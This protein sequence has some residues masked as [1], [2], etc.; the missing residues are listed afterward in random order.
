MLK[1][2]TVINRGQA[3]E[4]D[5]VAPLV[6]GCQVIKKRSGLSRNSK[7]DNESEKQRNKKAI[8]SQ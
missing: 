2:Q 3:N 4:G 1:Q 8:T 7:S 6:D 5:Q